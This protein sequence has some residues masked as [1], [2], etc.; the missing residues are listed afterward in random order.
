M[1][2]PVTY[3]VEN[4]KVECVKTCSGVFPG[5]VFFERIFSV[6]ETGDSN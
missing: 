6:G 5:K 4:K 1:R 2:L 3:N